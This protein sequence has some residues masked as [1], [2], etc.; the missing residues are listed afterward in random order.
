MRVR[1]MTSEHLRN[2]MKL[3]ERETVKSLRL[4]LIR[5]PMIYQDRI[6]E[7]LKDV[8]SYLFDNFQ[9]YRS[10]HK[11]R[12]LRDKQLEQYFNKII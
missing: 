1:E 5:Q 12:K 10:M 2:T 7:A 6:F 11:E 8:Q 9:P 4:D 3:I